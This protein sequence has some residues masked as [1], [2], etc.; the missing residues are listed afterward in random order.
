M[1]PFIM[2]EEWL[3]QNYGSNSEQ[4]EESAK[5][6][7]R[8]WGTNVS[9]SNIEAWA[10][11]KH[12]VEYQ[13]NTLDIVPRCLDRIGTEFES[14]LKAHRFVNLLRVPNAE[15]YEAVL[16]Q[17]KPTNIL[18][19]GV[20]GDSAISTAIFLSYIEDVPNGTVLSV[21]RNPLGKTF[22]RYSKFP[23]WRFMQ[24]DSLNVLRS[25]KDIHYDLIFVD[26]IHSFE[27]TLAEF[28]EASK[29][30]DNILVDDATFEGND[31]DAL[32]GGVK[33]ACEEFDKER[34]DWVYVN[35][36]IDSIG[37]FTRKE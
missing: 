27:H 12:L 34:D 29:I 11:W 3:H 22:E 24:D 6:W 32:P 17:V 2:T 21:D 15:Y 25:V 36:G 37:F 9:A 33:R 35:T 31:F 26:T 10:R 23:Q 19:L 30:T 1:N 7:L 8:K 28:E 13:V 18:E 14:E 4:Q 5:D 20:G 16:K